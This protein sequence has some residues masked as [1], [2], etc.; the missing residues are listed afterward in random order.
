MRGE[1]FTLSHVCA[2]HTSCTGGASASLSVLCKKLLLPFR[3][4]QQQL[5]PRC[6]IIETA[7]T[8]GLNKFP[9]LAQPWLSY[10]LRLV[11]DAILEL[12]SHELTGNLTTLA[13]DGY[14]ARGCRP[15]RRCVPKVGPDTSTTIEGSKGIPLTTNRLIRQAR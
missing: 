2:P 10:M 1:L 13:R 11:R 7:G 6:V 15:G 5:R 3:A 14:L 4:D 8:E 9:R 12:I